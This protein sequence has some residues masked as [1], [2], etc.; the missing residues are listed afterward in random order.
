MNILTVQEYLKKQKALHPEL[1]E[2]ELRRQHRN[3]YQREY[4]KQRKATQHTI[5]LRVSKKHFKN[6]EWEKKQLLHT[7]MNTFLLEC[8]QAY[9]HNGYVFPKQEE[10]KLIEKNLRA[11]ANTLQQQR[12]KVDAILKSLQSSP[13]NEKQ[14]IVFS[15]F[16]QALE[17][18]KEIIDV[19]KKDLT[20][21]L[22]SPLPKDM[23]ITWEE[24]KD[25]PERLE[26]LISFLTGH[27]NSLDHASD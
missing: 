3:Y 11:I 13:D 24:I 16:L 7:S 12:R 14:R 18:Q 21:Y 26:K 20:S 2:K 5:T 1:D 8:I 4:Q 9:L 27:K 10:T 17:L 22:T 15:Q 25:H 19:C 23:N 6:L